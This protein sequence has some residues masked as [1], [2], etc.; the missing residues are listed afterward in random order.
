MDV[1]DEGFHRI[2]MTAEYS[3]LPGAAHPASISG[4]R[5]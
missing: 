4:A 5:R 1:S 2:H 3:P